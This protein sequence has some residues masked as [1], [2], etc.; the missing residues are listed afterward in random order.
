[1]TIVIEKFLSH[2][3]AAINSPRA[4]AADADFQR[5]LHAYTEEGFKFGFIAV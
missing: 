5:E 4:D 1:M 2:D 3:C